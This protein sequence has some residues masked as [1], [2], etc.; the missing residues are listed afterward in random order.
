MPLHPWYTR[1]RRSVS[2]ATGPGVLAPYFE[3]P[4]DAL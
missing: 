1:I 2:R 3:G 4:Q